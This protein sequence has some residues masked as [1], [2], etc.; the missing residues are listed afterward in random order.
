M[1]NFEERENTLDLNYD[2]GHP[3]QYL[4]IYLRIQM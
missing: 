1:I 2:N 3:S 4:N